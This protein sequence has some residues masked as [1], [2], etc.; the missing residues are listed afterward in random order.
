D[1]KRFWEKLD[2]S[3]DRWRKKRRRK[4]D[5]QTINAVIDQNASKILSSLQSKGILNEI[6]GTIASGKEAGVFLAT[7]GSKGEILYQNMSITSPIV[8]KVFRTSTLNFKKIQT[9]ISGDIRFRKYSKKT[10]SFIKLWVEKEFRNLSRSI[11][12]GV[13]VPKPILVKNNVLLMEL[14]GKNGIPSPLLK[15]V[16][17]KA[18]ISTLETLLQQVS[19]LYQKAGLVHGDLSPYNIIMK[20]VTPYLIDMSQ[21]VLISHPNAQEF[22]KRDLSNL[23]TFFNKLNFPIPDLE[24]VY[25]VIVSENSE[26]ENIKV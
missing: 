22:L 4:E 13:N 2:D 9:Y 21:S 15:S 24:S 14:I 19:I 23:L 1:D 16:P 26:E 3:N 8:V 11:S 5:F 6:T 20:D 12:V 10:R 17:Q 25:E 7:L 18:S